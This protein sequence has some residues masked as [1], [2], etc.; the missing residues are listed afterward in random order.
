MLLFGDKDPRFRPGV[1]NL[2]LPIVVAARR[3]A[4]DSSAHDL[5]DLRPWRYRPSAGEVGFGLVALLLWSCT[6]RHM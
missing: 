5:F 3:R 2:D 1:F 4:T 6:G